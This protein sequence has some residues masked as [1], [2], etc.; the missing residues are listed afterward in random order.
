MVDVCCSPWTA[1]EGGRALL[2]GGRRGGGKDAMGEE[3]ELDGM[4]AWSSAPCLLLAAVEA[5][6]EEGREDACLGWKEEREK[7]CGD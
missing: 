5:R 7:C 6:E 3:P 1:R 4:G 2:A